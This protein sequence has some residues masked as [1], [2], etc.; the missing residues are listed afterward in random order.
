MCTSYFKVILALVATTPIIARAQSPSH[1]P[2]EAIA[3][4]APEPAPTKNTLFKLGT[5][6]TRGAGLGFGDFR[7]VSV[8]VVLG[9]EHHLSPAVSIYGNLS[10]GLHLTRRRYYSYNA[11]L[12]IDPGSDAGVRY[13]YNQEKRKSK[14]RATGP[15]VGN[16][17]ALHSSSAFYTYQRQSSTERLHIGYGYSSLNLIWGM[18]RRIG[19]HGLFDG[20]AGAG[21]SNQYTMGPGNFPDYKRR[22]NL[23]L[24]GVVKISLVP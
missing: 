7:G 10:T 9:V 6:L 5:G 12:L 14:G 21:V 15:F 2:T 8:P 13:Y 17:L 22:P 4:A 24:E 19:R 18:Q 11:P 1:P 20:Y 3:P 23:N 16:Y